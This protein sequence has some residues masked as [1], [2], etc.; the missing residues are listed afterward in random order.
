[1]KM[2]SNNDNYCFACSEVV[3]SNTSFY[4]DKFESLFLLR[5]LLEI[6]PESELPFNTI[7]VCIP[8]G[9]SIKQ[10]Q[11][12]YTEVSAKI[13][14]FWGLQTD[15]LTKILKHADLHQQK[16]N[17]YNNWV[18]W[19][20]QFVKTRKYIYYLRSIIKN[21]KDSISKKFKYYMHF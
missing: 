17:Q 9:S 4:L 5:V 21:T 1:M 16:P 2:A 10:C 13:Q 19:C 11:L 8:C 3:S 18:Y 15:I 12:I 20:K 7:Q 6:P 14:T